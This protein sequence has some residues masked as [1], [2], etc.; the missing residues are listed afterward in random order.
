MMKCMKYQTVL[1]NYIRRPFQK[2]YRSQITVDELHS[3]PNYVQHIETEHRPTTV[4]VVNTHE[5]HDQNFSNYKQVNVV[6][7]SKPHN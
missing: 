1:Q 3:I 7:E 4:F 6:A 5:R 2:P